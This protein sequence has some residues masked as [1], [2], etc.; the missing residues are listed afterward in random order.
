VELRC[1]AATCKFGEHLQ[2]VLRDR[3]VCGTQHEGTQKQFLAEVALTLKQV[4]EIARN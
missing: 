4:L 1:L 2:E 3:L